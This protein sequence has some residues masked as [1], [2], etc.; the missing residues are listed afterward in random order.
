MKTREQTVANLYAADNDLIDAVDKLTVGDL[1]LMP[2]GVL[3]LQQI[4]ASIVE[5]RRLLQLMLPGNAAQIEEQRKDYRRQVER[6]APKRG[7]TVRHD[8]KENYIPK[9]IRARKFLT[10]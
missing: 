10:D 4:Q 2:N 3:L 9:R 1:N 8:D 6:R 7:V 5:T